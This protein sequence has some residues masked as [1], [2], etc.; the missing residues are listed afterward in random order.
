VIDQRA[1]TIAPLTVVVQ[2]A[3]QMNL[4]VPLMNV[5]LQLKIAVVDKDKFVTSVVVAQVAQY[6]LVQLQEQA[7]LILIL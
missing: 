4:L 2:L 5:I 6:P 3:E 7:L 1:A